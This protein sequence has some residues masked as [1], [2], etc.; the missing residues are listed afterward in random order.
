MI[1]VVDDIGEMTDPV[2]KDDHPCLFCQLQIQF[3]MPM[4]V[5]EIIDI[6][7]ILDVLFRIEYKML[8]PFSHIGRLLAIRTLHASMLGPVQSETHTR[9]WVYRR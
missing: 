1:A 9:S 4:P 5:D 7:V 3:D 2:A 8:S 6:G